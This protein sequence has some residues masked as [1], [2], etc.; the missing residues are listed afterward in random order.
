MYIE[1]SVQSNVVDFCWKRGIKA[2]NENEKLFR[3][4]I[5]IS[6]NISLGLGFR[7][8]L[9][10]SYFGQNVISKKKCCEKMSFA[11]ISMY[12]Y[13]FV[14]LHLIDRWDWPLDQSKLEKVV[15]SWL[16]SVRLSLSTF[17]KTPSN[18]FTSLT[19]KHTCRQH[20]FI[21]ASMTETITYLFHTISGKRAKKSHKCNTMKLYPFV[22]FILLQNI[23][24]SV[25]SV[26]HS[27]SLFH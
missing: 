9:G 14:I 22:V 5:V 16:N 3:L 7:L 15:I 25:L 23:P 20:S 18:A 26:F 24:A 2:F 8:S 27:P 19:I 10:K 17:V 4:E 1:S 13:H 6:E 12:Q 11:L 21:N